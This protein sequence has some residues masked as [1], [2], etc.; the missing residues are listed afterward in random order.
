MRFAERSFISLHSTRPEE[1]QAGVIALFGCGSPSGAR[2][3]YFQTA[4]VLR[5]NQKACSAIV[6][7]HLVVLQ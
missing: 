6:E 4:M 3:C 2:R 1:L 5:C 7:G